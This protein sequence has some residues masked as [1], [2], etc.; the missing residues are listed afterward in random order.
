L[1]EAKYSLA[2]SASASEIAWAIVIIV[3]ARTPVRSPLL[4][5]A[6]WRMRYDTGSPARLDDSG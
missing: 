4:K 3:V 6:S 5:A 2:A 1:R